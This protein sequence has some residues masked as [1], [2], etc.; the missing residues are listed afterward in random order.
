MRKLAILLALALAVAL[1][2]A[3]LATSNS[4]TS[5]VS[6]QVIDSI[7]IAGVPAAITFGSDVAGST[8]TAAP[9]TL[10]STT[11]AQHGFTLSLSLTPLAN[12]GTTIPASA[13]K[14]TASA[15]GGSYCAA[16]NC[17]IGGGTYSGSSLTLLTVPAPATASVAVA[18]SLVIPAVAAGTYS[19]TATFTASTNP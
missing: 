7:T 12:G 17:T 5:P 16:N 13:T 1:P 10:S 8:V 2:G 19:G 3:A 15:P 14:W 11:S 6:V 18:P 4:G 9:F